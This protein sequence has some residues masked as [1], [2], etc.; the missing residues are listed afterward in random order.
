MARSAA[1][2]VMAH[3]AQIRWLAA[4]AQHRG[5]Y[6]GRVEHREPPW[7]APH[8]LPEPAVQRRL[9][10]VR[11]R[12]ERLPFVAGRVRCRVQQGDDESLDMEADVRG[13]DQPGEVVEVA[14]AVSAAL[15]GEDLAHLGTAEQVLLGAGQQMAQGAAG[16]DEQPGEGVVEE[17]LVEERDASLVDREHTF[18]GHHLDLLVQVVQECLGHG[19]LLPVAHSLYEPFDNGQPFVGSAAGGPARGPLRPPV[20]VVQLSEGPR[21][22]HRVDTG[23]RQIHVER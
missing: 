13:G 14:G 10:V 17:R 16:R 1:L 12:T 2:P 21:R 7:V 11:D 8:R 22:L 4:V 20:T 3:S 9:R 19:E 5:P 15:V 23:P 18:G 6:A